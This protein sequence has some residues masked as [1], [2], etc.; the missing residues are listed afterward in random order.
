M[1]EAQGQACTYR[2]V[3]SPKERHPRESGGPVAEDHMT[4]LMFAGVIDLLEKQ[5]IGPSST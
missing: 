5:E 1:E 3:I 4:L 2:V